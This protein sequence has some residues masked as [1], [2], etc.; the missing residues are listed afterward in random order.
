GS[1]PCGYPHKPLVSY[2]INRQLSGW[3]LPPLM[4]RAFGAHCQNRTLALQ[5]KDSLDYFRRRPLVPITLQ[6]AVRHIAPP[7]MPVRSQRRVNN[8]TGSAASAPRT[9]SRRESGATAS[10][11]T[12]T[13]VRRPTRGAMTC[14]NND[15]GSVFYRHGRSRSARG[16]GKKR[17]KPQG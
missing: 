13:S 8:R 4:I 1:D 17:R 2:R 3:I 14:R 5:Q 15:Q 6:K 11:A 16:R 12:R 9:G 10:S 7:K